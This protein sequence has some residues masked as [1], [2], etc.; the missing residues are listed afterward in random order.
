MSAHQTLLFETSVGSL[1]RDTRCCS[2]KLSSPTRFLPAHPPSGK[3]GCRDVSSPAHTE[4]APACMGR[5]RRC[6]SDTLTVA[7]RMAVLAWLSAEM[8]F[9][10]LS[11]VELRSAPGGEPT[12]TS[13][14][15]MAPGWPTVP[16]KLKTKLSAR[17]E[18]FPVLFPLQ[19][20]VSAQQGQFVPRAHV[21]VSGD[22]GGHHSY[23]GG[24][25]PLASVRPGMLL[26]SLH[27]TD[28]PRN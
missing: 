21:A 7:N 2:E 17:T 4:P 27:V 22:I 11:D 9:E 13:L 24:V 3:L 26:N 1:K 8:L 6:H 19:P 10:S 23:G 28:P 25:V 12:H 14:S 18:R 15:F 20:L 16:I 5:A